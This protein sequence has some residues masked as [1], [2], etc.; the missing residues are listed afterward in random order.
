MADN[1]SPEKR[2]STMR[3]VRGK[4]TSPEW[5]VRRLL[6]RLGYRYRLHARNLPGSPDI[7]FPARRKAIFVHGCFWHA[8][9]CSIGQP[10]KS[11]LDYWLPKLER[12]RERDS[13]KDAALMALGWKTLTVWQC[14]T[15][16]SDALAASLRAFLGAPQNS[17]R[18]GIR[19][20]L[21][22]NEAARAE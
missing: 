14:E 2:S 6:H 13:R 4:D 17:D 10:P 11:R 9:G 21:S 16:D 3:A 1:R 19:N 7:A 20:R 12:N 15:R 8:H 18:H 22:K 5:T